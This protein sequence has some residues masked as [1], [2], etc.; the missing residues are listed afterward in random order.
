MAIVR[1][2]GG[3]GYR[4]LFH[5]MED[6]VSSSFDLIGREV[7]RTFPAIDIIE[8]N[9]GYLIRADLPGMTKEEIQINIENDTLTIS[10]EK[11]RSVEKPEKNRYYH[12]ERG[13]GSFLRSLSLPSN[14][15]PNKIEA[16][17]SDGVLDIFI[18]K[19]EDNR[20]K[21]IEIKSE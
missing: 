3:G 18:K 12:F 21:S 1:Y 6:L 10:G 20:P 13:F 4:N 5:E 2:E 8:E 15:D 16:H 14:V 19:T 9:N 11:K 7:G 17:Y